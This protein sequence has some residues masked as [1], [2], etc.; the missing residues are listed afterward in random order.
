MAER[1]HGSDRC[2]SGGCALRWCQVV[3]IRWVPAAARR[4]RQGTRSIQLISDDRE[5]VTDQLAEIHERFSRLLNGAIPEVVMVALRNSC[6]RIGPYDRSVARG[7]LLAGLFALSGLTAVA[8]DLGPGGSSPGDPQQSVPAG[9]SQTGSDSLEEAARLQKE[10]DGDIDR[11]QYRDAAEKTQRALGIRRK[12][13]G[14]KHPDVAYSLNQMGILSYYQGDYG[15]AETLI[16]DALR[17]RETSLGS[18]DV[19]VAQSLGDLASIFLVRGDYVRPEPLYQRALDIYQKAAADRPS[20]ADLQGLI[21][22][23]FNNLGLL[24]H[25]RADYARAESQYLQALAIKERTRGP[26]DPTVAD[27]AANLG[28]VYYALEQYDKAV[29]VLRR[30]L[31]IQEKHLAPNHA[32]LATSSFNLAAVY[33][34]QGDYANAEALFQRALT[35]DEQS[36]DARHP[37]LA[38]RLTGLAEV[39]RLRGDYARAEPLYQRAL[40][41]REQALG[42][43]HPQV[44]DSLIALSLLR[45]AMGDTASA[46][47]LLSRGASLREETLSLVLTTGSEEA[48]RLYLQKLVDETDIAASIH[49]GTAPSSTPAATLAL[50]NVLQRKGRSL[51]A[52]AGQVG[53]LRTRLN[54]ADQAVFDQLSEA[55]GRLAKLV[56]SG[57]STDQQRQTVVQTRGE[58]DRLEQT[59]SARSTEFREVSRKVTL[60][61]VQ[62]TLPRGA[63]LIELV[64]YRPFSVRSARPDAFGAPHYAAYVL[65]PTGIVASVDLGEAASVERDIQ[66]FRTALSNPS[67][68]NVHEVARA[69]HRRVLEPIAPSLRNVKHLV[70]SPDGALNLIPFAAL[71]GADGKYLVERY[72][73]S[74]MTSGRDLIR[75]GPSGGNPARPGG[76]A[77]VIADP[78]FDALGTDSSASSNQQSRRAIDARVLEQLTQFEALPGT[79]EEATALAEVLPN[80]LVYTGR[81]ATEERLKQLHAPSILHIATHGFFLRQASTPA[82]PGSSVAPSGDRGDALVLSGL[83]LAGANQRS[84]GEGQDGILTAL[85]ATGLD[86]WGT[87]LV[88]LSAC[89]TGLGDARNGEGVYGLRRALVLAGSESQVMSLWRVSDT[90]T[91]DLM[92]GYYRRLRSREGRADALRNVQ[93]SLLRSRRQSHPFFWASFIQ[94]GDWRP[95]FD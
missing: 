7:L 6:C 42:P 85:E 37:R 40:T 27:T 46:L 18:E 26:D 43:A 75:L 72:T 15:R 8:H 81:Q 49:F 58:I 71:V 23:V 53:T 47:E 19:A 59:I 65:G 94:S 76:Q 34:D 54:A 89:E 13:L 91:R 12:Q 32:S 2:D 92:I 61:E 87:R 39:L 83:A 45:H 50:T 17:I 68:S 63:V 84:S 62:Q 73:V 70:I 10:A 9:E 69:M 24:Y 22:G 79:G 52:M 31:T 95:A 55:Q 74:Y 51:D 1:V 3:F 21:A 77:V 16:G 41:I 11:R 20:D 36:F 86:L 57:V 44:A 78:L 60:A 90:A 25:R 29:E 80:A 38:V 88:V 35:I 14:E 48:K 67:A 82:P 28:A 5:I 64:S 4:E 93:L 30:A 66:R 56:L 33:F